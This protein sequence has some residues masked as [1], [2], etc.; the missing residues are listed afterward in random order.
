MAP[1]RTDVSAQKSILFQTC[2]VSQG[3]CCM[4][5]LLCKCGGSL[6]KRCSH[7][8]CVN[9][10]ERCRFTVRLQ[11]QPGSQHLGLTVW[12]AS[13][14][15]AKYME[16]VLPCWRFHLSQMCGKLS[17][18]EAT[19]HDT[20]SCIYVQKPLNEKHRRFATLVSSVSSANYSTQLSYR[21]KRC[22][23]ATAW[24]WGQLCGCCTAL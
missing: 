9:G 10:A 2:S 7:W 23:S 19:V 15:C 14:V 1:P 11:Q 12:D 24:S 5:C 8:A 16:K 21:P 13:I 20:M 4:C 18:L 3:I 17:I 22:P 6:C